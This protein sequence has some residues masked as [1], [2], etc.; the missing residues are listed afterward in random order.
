MLSA[1]FDF[2]LPAHLIAQHP[3]RERSASRLLHVR[4]PATGATADDRPQLIDRHFHALPALLRPGDLL[5]VNDSRVMAA[6]LLGRKSTGG[7]IEILIERLLGPV[8]ALAMVRA[9]KSPP[10]GSRLFIDGLPDTAAG[11]TVLGRRDAFY[12]LRFDRPLDE[13]MA[14][15]GHLPLPPYIER[16]PDAQDSERYQTV[17][18]RSSGSVAAP[19]AGLHFDQALLDALEAGGVALARVTLHVG[20]GTFAPVRD[21]HVDAHR[22]HEERYVIPEQTVAAI[23]ATRA[24]GGRVI[25]VGTTSLRSLESAARRLIDLDGGRSPA[26]TDQPGASARRV[27]AEERRAGLLAGSGAT[28]L[29]LRPGDGFA[30]VDRLI[31]NFHLPR[32]TLIMLVAAFAGLDTI[33]RAYAHAI[34]QEYRFFSYGDAMF[35]DLTPPRMAAADAQRAAGADA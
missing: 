32:S 22:M 16:T 9:S 7:R 12:E 30:V 8:D 19:T 3:L 26:D 4:E 35:L 31:T 34:A 15:A 23:A 24:R 18:S 11:V 29:F 10:A 27:S 17:Y 20:A 21:E 6:R 28:R 2:P 33:R 5:V 1:E 25:A 13:V 14:A